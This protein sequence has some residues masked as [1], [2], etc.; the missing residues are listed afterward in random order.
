MHFFHF[1]PQLLWIGEERRAGTASATVIPAQRRPFMVR[2]AVIGLPPLID[3]TFDTAIYPH[4][5]T[6]MRR[7]YPFHLLT[8]TLFS[9]ITLL[10]GGVIGGI[11]YTQQRHLLLLAATDTFAR[12][13]RES[14]SELAA[15]Y[16]PAK[17]QIDLLALALEDSPAD[18]RQLA[19]LARVLQSTPAM[20]SISVQAAHGGLLTLSPLPHAE[21]RRRAEAP[22][23]AAYRLDQ[24]QGKR[25][26]V[27]YFDANLVALGGALDKRR[28]SIPD[29]APSLQL[30]QIVG[31]LNRLTLRAHIGLKNLSAV[32]SRQRATPSAQL[33]MLDSAGHLLAASQGAWPSAAEQTTPPTLASMD[34]PILAAVV[35][36]P[37]RGQILT[38][39]IGE[40]RWPRKAKSHPG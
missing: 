21:A 31:E 15:I 2:R 35:A 39:E 22:A 33:A 9:L 4:P 3:A 26:R 16:L 1:P 25:T 30:S 40:R 29:S 14:Q 28:A 27:R 17:A 10:V 20:S 6:A 37:A 5:P 24:E 8:A 36:Q 18:E 38:L 32:L 11:A 23:A 34:L 7:T 12:S 13:L 19:M